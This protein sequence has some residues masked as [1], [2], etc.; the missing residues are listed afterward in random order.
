[1][2]NLTC[3]F[4]G[5][6]NPLRLTSYIFSIQKLPELTYFV[7]STEV[8][9]LQLGSI[10]QASNV[11]DIKIPGETMDY[12][13]LN[14]EFQ[15]DEEMKNWNAIYFW[16]IGLGYPEGHALYRRYQN[17]V[18]N[19]NSRTELAKGYSDGS[20]TILDSSNNPKQIFTF[21]DMFPTN[22]SGLRFDA[23]QSEPQ[24]AMATATF[25]YT[26]YYINKEVV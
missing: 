7:Q 20:L 25:E 1:M 13:T 14:I 22:L 6:I 11:H 26:Y 15:I 23:G 24:I 12:G 2:P 19:A 4:P 17:A 5:N 18:V 10:S 3:P 21:V 16:M 9:S 8:P